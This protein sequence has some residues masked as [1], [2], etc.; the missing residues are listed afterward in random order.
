MTYFVSSCPLKRAFTV[1]VKAT[2]I[3]MASFCDNVRGLGPLDEAKL[4]MGVSTGVS[5]PTVPMED[6]DDQ[7]SDEARGA[8]VDCCDPLPG[9]NEE[10][11]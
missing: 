2:A 9:I 11:L 5:R 7:L 6:S 1:S 8:E 3:G 4:S 10:D